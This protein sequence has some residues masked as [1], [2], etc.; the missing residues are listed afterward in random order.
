MSDTRETSVEAGDDVGLE[1]ENTA[2]M[3]GAKG[4]EAA[5]A[6][7]QAKAQE[8]WDR[9]VR[10][11][12]E[13]ENIRRRAAKDLESAHKFALEK[14]VNELLPVMDGMELGM[15]AAKE[16]NADVSKFLEGSELTMKMFQSAME[17]FN[18]E[19]VNPVGEKFNP[20]LHQAI[21]IQENGTVEANTVMS[22]VQKG[23]TLQ[24]RL[25]R[26]ALVIV[27]KG[28]PAAPAGDTTIDERA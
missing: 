27:S 17:K 25:M 9:Y 15:A 4:L 20:D 13:M 10:A 16:Q 19:Q 3:E 18:V 12:A 14:F 11:N 5:L 21:S 1:N 23:Y 6:D 7:A 8:N 28:G 24:G 26:P 2:E 22:V